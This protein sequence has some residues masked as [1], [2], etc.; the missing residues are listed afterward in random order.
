MLIAYCSDKLRHRYAFAVLPLLVTLAGF[1]I[2]AA[3]VQSRNV[4]YGSLFLVAMGA[5]T[6]MFSPLLTDTFNL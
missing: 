3:N 2:L 4:K 5:Y 1:G 6:G